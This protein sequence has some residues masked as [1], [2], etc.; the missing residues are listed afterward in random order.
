MPTPADRIRALNERPLARDRDH[1]VYWMTA[2][3][4]P[5][6]SFAL[7]RAV[8]LAVELDRPLIVLE[9]LR[10]GYRWAS[11][12]FHRFVIDGM[13]DHAAFFE[14]RAVAYHPYVE[15]EAGA[16]RGLLAALGERACAVVT[17]D[18]PCFFLPRMQ[19]AAAAALDVRLEAVDGNGL[20][21]IGRADKAFARAH[22]FR[23][24]L[25]R[26]LPRQLERWPLPDPTAN[27]ALRP[28]TFPEDVAARWPRASDALLRGDAAALAK[29]PIDHGVGVVAERGGF[30]SGRDLV[31]QFVDE[32]LERYEDRSHPD[33]EVVSTLSPWLHFGQVSTHAIVRA[34]AD[35]EGWSPA[36]VDPKANGNRVGFWGTSVAA[37]GFLD[38]LVTWRE[39]GLNMCRY[40]PGYDRYASLPAWAKRTLAEH[41]KDTRPAGYDLARLEAAQTD[42]ELWNA[43]QRELVE[44]GRMHNYLR[45]LWGKKIL[46]WAPMPEL[47]LA[48]MITLNDKY[49]LD[50]RDPNSYS[51]I[52][53]VLGRYDRAWGPERDVFGKIR[54]MTSDSARRKLKLKRYLDRWGEAPTLF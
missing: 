7:E 16:G 33:A 22:D 31:A 50:G 45:M 5:G 38:Q 10:V 29:L 21:P 42:D 18:W 36:E 26:E 39:L 19:A 13:A 46:G 37:E 53:W 27:A 43:A 49:A 14:P 20:M 3:R 25:H 1:V 32:R 4:R 40:E 23:R 9:P 51:G 8:D 34:I 41:A 15:P 30:A 44:T 54:Y 47:A 2:A 6:S 48:W 28:A 35:R 11:D 24:Y 12:R 17:D 52:F